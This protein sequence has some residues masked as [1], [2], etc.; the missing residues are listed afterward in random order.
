M[1]NDPAA[2]GLLQGTARLWLLRLRRCE[3]PVLIRLTFYCVVVIFLVILLGFVVSSVEDEFSIL[4]LGK[5]S[6]WMSGNIP[7]LPYGSDLHASVPVLRASVRRALGD[8]PGGEV[9]SWDKI[10]GGGVI[11]VLYRVKLRN[12]QNVTGLLLRNLT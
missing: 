6:L 3:K 4:T 11:N 10:E 5:A 7:P 1:G 9:E 12:G 2:Q 8:G